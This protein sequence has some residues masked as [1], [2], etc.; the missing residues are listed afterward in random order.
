[1]S[2]PNP[3][4]DLEGQVSEQP[5]DASRSSPTTGG[6]QPRGLLGFELI[7]H[8]GLSPP[9]GTAEH[10]GSVCPTSL[11]QNIELGD[12]ASTRSQAPSVGQDIPQI[13]ENATRSQGANYSPGEFFADPWR[14]MWIQSL[15]QF[16]TYDRE[17]TDRWKSDADGVLVFTGLFSATVAAFVIESYKRLSVDSGDQTVTL[18]SQVSQQ[19]VGISNG[20]A[21][22]TPPPLSNAPPNLHSAIRVNILFLLSLAISLTCALLA[23]LIQQWTRR[24]MA[25]S[26]LH[27]IPHERARVRTVLFTGMERFRMKQTVEAIPMLLHTSVFLFFAG[28]VDFFLLFNKSVAWVFIGWLGL[29]ASLYTALTVIPNI[30]LSCPYGTPFTSFLWRLSQMLAVITLVFT[31]AFATILDG[32]LQH[33]R[34]IWGQIYRGAPTSIAPLLD[35]EKLVKQ[36]AIHKHWFSEGFHRRVMSDASNGSPSVDREALIWT[37]SKLNE[38]KEVED[39]LSRIPGFFNSRVVLGAS[40]TMLRLMDSPSSGG[41]SVLAVRLGGLL[42]TCLP[43]SSG[44]GPNV[45]KNRF[46]ICLTAIWYYMK[47]YNNSKGIPMSKSFRGLFAD[48]NEMKTLLVNDDIRIN[49]MVLCIG[50]L[51]VAGLMKEMRGQE[52]PQ[53]SEGELVFIKKALGPL[54]RLDLAGHQPTQFTNLYW[55]MSNL[56][57]I[58][59]VHM[60]AGVTFGHEVFDTMV[61]LAE[62]VIDAISFL[63]L[64]ENQQPDLSDLRYARG[65]LDLCLKLSKKCGA[66]VYFDHLKRTDALNSLVKML[67]GLDT[68]IARL[69]G[70][71]PHPGSPTHVHGL[72]E[73]VQF[74]TPEDYDNVSSAISPAPPMGKEALTSTLAELREDDEFEAF[75]A[76]ISNLYGP[77]HVSD[78]SI[79]NILDLMAPSSEGGSTLAPR[80]HNFFKACLPGMSTWD[81]DVRKRRL[82]VCLTVIWSH[83]RAYCNSDPR[84]RP[85]PGQFQRLF[86]DSDDMDIISAEGDANTQV[87]VLCITS[88]LVTKFVGDI[89]HRS[90]NPPVSEEELAFVQKALGSFWRPN[91][92]LVSPGPAELANFLAMLDGLSKLAHQEMP[93]LETLGREASE[94]LEILARAVQDSLPEDPPLE[95]WGSSA[96]VIE[97]SRGALQQC[98]LLLGRMSEGEDGL[99]KCAWVDALIGRMTDLDDKLAQPR[100]E[101]ELL[102]GQRYPRPLRDPLRRHRG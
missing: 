78:T 67:E 31:G 79:D 26:Y 44:V 6:Q 92:P 7:R 102:T 14:Q 71:P 32:F 51:L 1:M 93:S 86:A 41:D 80:L 63:P 57:A 21:L 12:S 23:T 81:P 89:R 24:Y 99:V 22:P 66:D 95:P 11:V 19:L 59:N 35:R 96:P 15:P 76:R 55:M 38:D 3:G 13:P 75:V 84:K 25:L 18:L 5:F 10:G 65:L 9:H 48:Q 36:I 70:P 77:Y 30:I 100:S 62:D 46:N 101:P 33:S 73:G 68:R 56:V 53:V 40:E 49:V 45:D 91:L 43:T 87:M 8:L 60:P 74:T 17:I 82:R 34:G 28:L 90:G 2:L 39:Y 20:T 83:A 50:S 72:D 94:T 4:V 54:W 88:L 85:I 42:K 52:S 58:G 27:D 47:V 37:L 97:D 16:Q 69:A 29:F 64:T 61:I 98:R